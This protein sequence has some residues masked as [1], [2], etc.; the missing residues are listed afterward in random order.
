METGATLSHWGLVMADGND[1]VI[2]W[3]LSAFLALC[4]GNPPVTG[5]FPS[6]RPVTQS[7]NV[8]FLCTLTY[9]WANN[10]GASDLRPHCV[11]HD[12]P[13]MVSVYRVIIGWYNG[14]LPVWHQAI[15]WTTADRL[16]RL[17]GT[18]FCEISIKIK[19]FKK[20]H[21]GQFIKVWLYCY[22]VLVS[23][24]NKIR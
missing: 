3:K 8:F 5:G 23:V 12:V 19:T 16:S 10:Q 13:V 21:L 18:N 9:G 6:Q 20:T 4:E 17:P 2:K 24:D 1:D 7:F 11:H 22:L 14:L 15:D